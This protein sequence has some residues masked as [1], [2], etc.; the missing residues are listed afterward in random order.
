LSKNANL[1]FD[2][3]NAEG[4]LAKYTINDLEKSNLLVNQTKAY[5]VSLFNQDKSVGA[6]KYQVEWVHS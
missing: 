5:Q 6:I 2:V 1:E 3:V 4:T